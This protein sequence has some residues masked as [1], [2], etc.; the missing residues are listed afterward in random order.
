LELETL[1]SV[2]KMIEGTDVVEVEVEEAGKKVRVRRGDV[3]RP[4]A[5]P[6]P[7]PGPA[8]VIAAPGPLAVPAQPT[9]APAP[10]AAPE[11]PANHHALKSPIVGTFYR[12]SDP[13]AAPFAKV[14]DTVRKGQILCIVE[15]MKL[16]NEIE[17]DVAGEIVKVHPENGHPVQFGETLFT[18]KTA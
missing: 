17:A 4:V 13:T 12:A 6:A 14:G 10:V 1:K 2:L 11:A 3:H 7:P 9:P 15:A 8:V 16:M 18:I 5:A